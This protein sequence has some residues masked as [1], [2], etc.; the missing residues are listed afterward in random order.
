[1]KYPRAIKTTEQKGKNVR[2]KCSKGCI[3]CKICVNKFPEAGFV[4]D[5][6]LS[7]VDYTIEKDRSDVSNACPIKCIIHPYKGEKGD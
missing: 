4:V 3:A 6:N 2:S 1:M 7:S 5:K